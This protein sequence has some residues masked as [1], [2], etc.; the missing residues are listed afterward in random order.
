MSVEKEYYNYISFYRGIPVYVGK[1]KGCRSSHTLCGRSENQDINDFHFRWKYFNDIPLE[2]VKVAWFSSEQDA[3]ANEAKLIKKYKPYCNASSKQECDLYPFKD[4]LKSVSSTLGFN[5]PE[6][7]FSKYDFKFLFTPKGLLCHK[8]AL[9]ENSPFERVGTTGY[10]K[11]RSSF[12]TH[13]PEFAY[14]F[15]ENAKDT[16][17]T[18]LTLGATNWY[19]NKFEI[20][21]NL[22]S[23]VSTDKEWLLEAL[24]G[25]SYQYLKHFKVAR[26][27]FN[28][29]KFSYNFNLKDSHVLVYKELLRLSN[30]RKL[31]RDRKKTKD[32]N[33]VQN[34]TNVKQSF[35]TDIKI[36]VS[37][38]SLEYL[39]TMGFNLKGNYGYAYI[40]CKK[41]PRISGACLSTYKTVNLDTLKTLDLS[42]FKRE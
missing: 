8:I 5:T 10:I 42:L 1:G 27:V 11:V 41:S 34:N 36:K 14:L 7:L 32:A 33:I 29:E 24:N 21:C 28:E 13:F 30:M 12:Y 23:S 4:K 9:D 37:L 6:D 19:F 2:T 15:M 26:N 3:Y 38:E 35:T 31:C 17:Y 40:S 18:H 39:T 16:N 25:E 20:G 22:L